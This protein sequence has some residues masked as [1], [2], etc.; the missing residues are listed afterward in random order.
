MDCDGCR[1]GGVRPTWNFVV[2]CKVFHTMILYT[3]EAKRGSNRKVERG[4]GGDV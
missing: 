2:A 3:A 1:E 4:R